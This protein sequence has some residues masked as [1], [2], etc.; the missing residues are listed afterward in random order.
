M[1]GRYV[2]YM[3][4]TVKPRMTPEAAAKLIDFYR[5]LREND[6]SGAQRSAYRIT[7]RQV[8]IGRAVSK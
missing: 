7:V 4:A 1:V 2:Q 5:Q 6:C 3:R 8:R